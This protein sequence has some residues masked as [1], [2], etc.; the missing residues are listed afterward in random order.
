MKAD[1]GWMDLLNRADIFP[2]HKNAEEAPLVILGQCWIWVDK[3]I[4]T[5]AGRLW[6][7]ELGGSWDSI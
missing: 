6:E 1:N 7:A 5:P 2:V 4:M 3:L